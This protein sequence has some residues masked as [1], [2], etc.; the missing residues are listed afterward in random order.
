MKEEKQKES[1][2]QG[3]KKQM[4]NHKKKGKGQNPK[5]KVMLSLLLLGIAIYLFYTIYLLVRQPTN[6]FTVEEGKL[7]LEETCVGYVIRNEQVIKGDNY[8]NGMEQIKSEGE[9]AAKGESVF[10]Y[11]SKNED[12]L[13]QQIA[14][15]D[16]KIQEAMT[17]QPNLFSSDMKLLEN[18]IDQKVEILNQVTDVSKLTEYKKEITDLVTKKAKIAGETSN[19]GSY[20]KQLINQRKTLENELNSGAEYVVAPMSGIVSYKV[21]G[22][23]E[24]LKL[25]NFSTLSKEYLEG[26]D[27]KTGKMIATNDESG[28]IIDN[29]SCYI[30]TIS[31]SEQAKKAKQGDNVKL[32]LSNNVEIKAEI[33]YLSQENEEERLLILKI[34]RQISELIDYRKISFDLIWSSD[35]GLRVPNQAIVEE[36]GLNYIVR[37]RAGY[38]SKILVKVKSKND[39]YAIVT[40]YKTEE[41]AKLGFTEKEINSYKK[42]T[43]YD[44]IMANPD[45]SKI[46]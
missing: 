10:R 34:D 40:N 38:L 16:G 4:A 25:D 3:N 42:I 14:E 22:L 2:K 33:S 21:D 9:K 32:R 41:L 1:Q 46:K 7:Y 13:K 11:Y 5:N 20:L 35:E 31:D 28:K 23:E 29:F 26:L 45:L 6:I 17:N 44:E 36:N 15:L 43:L 30:A 18:Q 12:K 24:V 19:S 37:N 8:K 39:K 27:I